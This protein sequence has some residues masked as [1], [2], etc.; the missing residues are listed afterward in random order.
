MNCK[1]VFVFDQNNSGSC[2]LS[3]LCQRPWNALD[4]QSLLI[5]GTLSSTAV[6]VPGLLSL[7]PFLIYPIPF[8]FRSGRLSRRSRLVASAGRREL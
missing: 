6:H 7:S 3:S 4:V 2:A 1:F 5:D 8:I